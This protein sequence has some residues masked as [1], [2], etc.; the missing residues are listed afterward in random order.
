MTGGRSQDIN[1]K[2]NINIRHAISQQTHC[3]TTRLPENSYPIL[4]QPSPLPSAQ[5]L[6]PLPRPPAHSNTRPSA[7]L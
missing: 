7:T 6:N 5:R 3:K 2:P 1:A 4:V